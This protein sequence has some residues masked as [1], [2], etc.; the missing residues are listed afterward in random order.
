MNQ[1]QTDMIKLLEQEGELNIEALVKALSAS[2]A[3]IRRDLVTLEES[4][5][6][7]RTFGGARIVT[8]TSLVTSTFEQKRGTMRKEKEQIARKAAELV[9]PGM[10]IAIDSGTTAWRLAAALKDKTPL[11]VI[12]SALA[13]FEELGA[14]EGIS[15]F[16][17]GGKFRLQN[18][19]FVGAS[20][21][22]AFKKLNADIAF[23][24]A[25]SMIPGRGAYSL[26]EQSS[27]VARAMVSVANV[28]VLLADHAKIN[29]HGCFQ[30]LSADEIDY[31]I[32][33]NGIDP[34]IKEKLEQGNCKLIIA[35]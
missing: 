27:D 29:S 17:T 7:V 4:G 23:F 33:D 21:I 18:L 15:I 28:K 12:T 22:D 5:H 14:I 11:K 32:T 2:E 9:K 6:L 8:A 34:D 25:D 13:V 16:C 20:T 1:R 24:G 31:M 35:D 26:D 30:V 10:V 19:D 3:T